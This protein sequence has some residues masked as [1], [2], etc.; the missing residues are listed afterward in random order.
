MNIEE[1]RDYCLSLPYVWESFP[2][3]EHTLVLKVGS[4]VMAILPLER[5]EP[6]LMLKCEPERALFLRDHYSAIEAAWHMNKRHWNGLY[7]SR[8]LSSSLVKEL[9][10]HSYEL[11]WQGLSKRERETLTNTSQTRLS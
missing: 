4:K 9:I 2:F 11:V 7:L 5:Y 10:Q 8:G 1:V 3:D 6:Y